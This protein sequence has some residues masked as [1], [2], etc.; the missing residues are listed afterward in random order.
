MWRTALDSTGWPDIGKWDSSPPPSLSA[1]EFLS[2]APAKCCKSCYFSDLGW[3]RYILRTSLV[4]LSAVVRK[5][6]SKKPYTFR[7]GFPGSS[8]CLVSSCQERPLTHL[9]NRGGGS[10]YALCQ[11]LS[12]DHPGRGIKHVGAA[13]RDQEVRPTEVER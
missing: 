12:A 3:I 1:P 9:I 13:D 4:P 5:P 11:G 7:T 6:G 10:R 8:R 2:Q